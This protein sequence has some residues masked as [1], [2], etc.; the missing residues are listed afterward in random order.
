MD[1][2]EAIGLSAV[3][4]YLLGELSPLE[5]DDFEEHFFSCHD[6]ATDVRMTSLLL[7]G[8]R[9]ELGRGRVA[10]QVVSR[11]KRGS[12]ADWLAPLWRPAFL[13][14]VMALLLLVVGYQN[15]V[16]YPHLAQSL[17]QLRQPAVLSAVSLI[18]ANSRAGGRLQI[19]GASNQPV[20]LSVDIPGEERFGSYVCELVTASGAVLWRVPVSSRQARDTVSIGVPAGI[21]N[22]GDYV[23]VVRG[24]PMQGAAPGA[25]SGVGSGGTVDLA[26]YPFTLRLSSANQP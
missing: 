19:N 14:P 12:L 25:S 21:L 26:R 1:H 22:P 5:R 10:E 17:A 13:G 23:L 9:K 15:V 4:R 24:T 11:W 8:T 18:A 2:Q 16:V 3:E 20:L 6:C 7:D